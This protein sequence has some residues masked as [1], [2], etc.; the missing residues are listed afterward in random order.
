MKKL[1]VVLMV[2]V[3]VMA[4]ASP[5]IV[6]D[7]QQGISHYMVI[8][9]GGVVTE[10]PAQADGSLKVDVATVSTGQ[11]N[12]TIRACSWWECSEPVPFVFTRAGIAVPTGIGLRK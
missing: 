6:S 11:H 2:L 8:I 7:A 5:F 3:P 4:F 1:L 12:I 9:D 10:V